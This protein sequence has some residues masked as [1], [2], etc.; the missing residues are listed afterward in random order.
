LLASQGCVREEQDVG[1]TELSGSAGDGHEGPTLIMPNH[2]PLNWLTD[3]PGVLATEDETLRLVNGRRVA[4]GLDVLIMQVTQRRA[5][6][7]HSRHMRADCHDFFMHD[8]PEGLS[9]GDRLRAN[10][11][12]WNHVAENIASGQLT[13]QEVF[14]D[15]VDSPGH[16]EHIDDPQ[17]RRTGLGYQTGAGG[18]DWPTFWTQVFTD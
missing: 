10:G 12:K 15:W 3:D 18:S 17:Y 4:L 6:R 8:N 7:G 2:H 1:A 9:P 13:P 5:A 11:V 16:R 14:T